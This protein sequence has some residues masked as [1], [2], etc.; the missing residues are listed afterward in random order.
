MIKGPVALPAVRVSRAVLDQAAEITANNF[1]RFHACKS[2]GHNVS[3]EC[4][5]GASGVRLLHHD[6][7][8]FEG[9][10]P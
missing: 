8:Y 7:C 6:T 5:S 3:T 2:R 9:D 4:Q 10:E 1:T